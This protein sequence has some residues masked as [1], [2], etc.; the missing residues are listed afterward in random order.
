MALGRLRGI[1]GLKGIADSLG[2]IG[3]LLKR[4]LP[5]IGE[6]AFLKDMF[7]VSVYRRAKDIIHDYLA[8]KS[9]PAITGSTY[10]VKPGGS[11][12]AAGTS[13]ATAFATVARAMNRILFDGV[14]QAMVGKIIVDTSAGDVIY[15]GPNGLGGTTCR[16]SVVIEPTGPGKVIIANTVNNV[17][18]FVWTVTANPPIHSTPCPAAPGF[19]F[20]LSRIVPG[21][22]AHLPEFE[23]LVLGESAS[24]LTPGQYFYDVA[25]TTLYVRTADGRAPDEKIIP[26]TTSGA[27]FIW[28]PQLSGQV[29]WM[30]GVH[31]VGGY[32]NWVD[33]QYMA[34]ATG[35]A[36][37]NDCTFQGTGLDGFVMT[38]LGAS[39]LSRCAAYNTIG[40]GFSSYAGAGG[41]SLNVSHRV[42]LDCRARRNGKSGNLANNASTAHDACRVAIINPDYGESQDRLIHFVYA[43][44]AWIVGGVLGKSARVSGASSR[45]VMVNQ[46]AADRTPMIFMDS[47]RIEGHSE[48]DIEA[49]NY[50]RVNLRNIDM[51]G[52]T[53]TTNTNG[54]I[55]AYS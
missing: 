35:K 24:A 3:S 25:A 14:S 11:D 43:S 31:F 44:L 4:V 7:G 55:A 37:L 33:Y 26:T 30:K 49:A 29:M 9:K 21:S 48:I 18:S 34:D 53:T 39:L 19:V 27:S 36:W 8:E 46:G 17:A 40:D 10:Y 20:D 47:V 42:E 52:I 41:N 32:Q 23:P 38:R 13:M 12:V 16:K 22:P 15:T 54:V 2:H 45:T 5:P 6:F 28:G 51:A 50:G 1:K